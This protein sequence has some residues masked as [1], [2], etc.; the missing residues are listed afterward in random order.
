MTELQGG[1]RC[2][3]GGDTCSPP[4]PTV[5]AMEGVHATM[6]DHKTLTQFL[7]EQR[8]AQ[9]GETT[10]D[11]NSLVTA[12][13]TACKVIS[14][15]IAQ[16]KLEEGAEAASLDQEALDIFGSTVLRTGL[17]CGLVSDDGA[18]PVTPPR[19][20]PRG[21]YALITDQLD[22]A[23]NIDLNGT[24][25]TT[26]SI[27]RTCGDASACE[28][29]FLQAGSQQVVAGYAIYGPSTML[30]LTLGHGTH[31][32]TLDPLTGEWRQ[33]HPHIRIQ[34][35]ANDFHI[36]SSYARFWESPVKRYVDE[37]LRGSSGDRGRDFNMRWVASLV[38][39]CHRILMRGGVF[40][41]PRLTRD[42]ARH[43]RLFLL[44]EVN[45]IAMVVKQ[46]GGKVTTGT[47]SPLD[48]V[49]T[50][51]A[52]HSPFIFGS[53]KEVARIEEYHL[54]QDAFRSFTSPLFA[55]RGLFADDDD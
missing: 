48:T 34:E 11:L 6:D 45:P 8:R 15:R 14:K 44:Q 52:Q 29:D 2:R 31:G 54:D 18:S 10:G 43:G 28:S 37:C 51:L 27:L 4:W 20:V 35:T 36:N 55:E 19:F 30:V 47:A 7:I 46:A 16:G 23:R 39:D 50:G 33:T 5:S 26:F 1:T 3:C 25:G 12:V 13:A 22:G 40:L 49:P 21:H 24:V 32:F 53:A 38:A 9:P 17:T 41:S 42:D